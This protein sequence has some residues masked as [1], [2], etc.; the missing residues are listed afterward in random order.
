M[1]AGSDNAFPQYSLEQEFKPKPLN[2]NQFGTRPH[3][4]PPP[5]QRKGPKQRGVSRKMVQSA[6][7][8]HSRVTN[9]GNAHWSVAEIS[10]NS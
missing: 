6:S 7:H 1:H 9:E 2:Q 10:Y 4:N 8:A 5:Q 3:R